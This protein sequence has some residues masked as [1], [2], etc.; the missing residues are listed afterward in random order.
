MIKL[1]VRVA[2]IALLSLLSVRWAVRAQDKQGGYG[3]NLS[4]PGPDRKAGEGEGPFPRLI[5]RG[6]T[7]IDG[8]G[9]PP[10]GPVDIVIEQNRIK[11][12][13]GVG[14]PKLPI[15]E[16]SRPKGAAKEINAAGM[17]A[18]PGFIDLHGHIRPGLPAEY[19]YKLWLA[20]GVTTVRDAASHN[21]IDWTIAERARSA[22]NRIVAPRIFAYVRTEGAYTRAE[23]DWTGGPIETPEAA[24]AYVRWAAKK[25]V[26]GFK[27]YGFDPEVMAAL[28]DE[29]RKLGLGTAAH[30]SQMAVSRM[31]GLDAARLGLTSLEHWY[32][33]PEAL[34]ADRSVQ[35]YPRGYNYNDEEHRFGEAGRLWAQAAP[36]G[37]EKW[38]AVMN[39]LLKLGLVIDSTMTVY[40]ASR[41]LMRAMRAEWHDTYTLPLVW[42]TYQPSRARHGA[43]WYYWTTE[44]ELA[45]KENYRLWM[46]FLNEYKNRGGHVTTGTDSGY[47]YNLYGFAYVRE[48]ELLREAGFHPLEVIRAATLHGAEAIFKPAGKPIEF[49]IIRPGLLA[50]L[51]IV[52]ENPLENLKALYGTGA[53]R[54]DDQTGRVERVGGVKWVVKDGIVHDAKHLLADVADMVKAAK[55]RPTSEVSAGRP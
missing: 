33:L 6:V 13:V 31:N 44:D 42:N 3:P 37:S 4:V 32:G 28:V 12:V 5:I 19:I 8:T 40:E 7:M 10:Q 24:R 52:E 41:D 34:F 46:A 17:Y 55:A 25:G 18:M 54:L 16:A 27:T 35:D 43:Y 14:V 36:P 21:G 48:L 45:W 15:K 50:D 51:A 11:E 53:V 30:L 22:S 1:P 49:G 2:A 20:H 29:A 9:A 23:K 38:N 47:I 39:E 26:D